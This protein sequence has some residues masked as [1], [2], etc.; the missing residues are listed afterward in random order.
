MKKLRGITLIELLITILIMSILASVAGPSFVDSFKNRR[1]VSAAEELY[2]HLQLARSEALSGK[3]DP[4]TASTYESI[5]I[6]FSGTGSTSWSYGLSQGKAC[7]PTIT[8]N[9][10]SNACVLTI[11]NGDGVYNS[12]DDAVLTRVDGSIYDDV[13]L[14]VSNN[15]AI[16]YDPVRGTV[17]RKQIFAFTGGTGSIV[18]VYQGLLG[19]VVM[20]SSDL[21]EYKDCP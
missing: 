11:D 5:F 20:C 21:G 1:L 8:N 12:A 2:S 10:D 4:V 9:Q 6:S 14:R 3:I 19:N 17:D 18:I 15:T 7:T 16:E 13:S